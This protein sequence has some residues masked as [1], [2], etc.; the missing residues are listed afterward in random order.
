MTASAGEY[1]LYSD[2]APWWPLISPPGEYAAE[3]ARLAEALRAAGG[4]VPRVLDLG[5]GGGHVAWHLAEGGAFDLTLVDLSPQMLEVSRRLNPG[6]EHIVGDM[7]TIR[8]GR[9][10]DGVIVHDAVDYITTRD[11]LALVAATAFAHCR[12]AGV[13][14]FVP[15]HVRDTF[16]EIKGGG[17]GSE[18]GGQM[19]SFIEHTWDPDP[20]DD[21][22]LAEYEFTLRNADGSE[23]VISEAHRLG[24]FSRAT[25]LRV[26]GEAGF[27]VSRWRADLPRAGDDGDGEG[28]GP[29]NLFIGRRP[30]G[31]G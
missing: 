11:D 15:D 3:T 25:W 23:A 5:S 9:S 6:L 21:W 24:A 30:D 26:L 18:P 7:R 27:A 16:A 29:A 4:G 13:A 19:A 12:P 8:L 2:L 20:A 31:D 17:G 10:F 1:R 14:L 28:G 22:V